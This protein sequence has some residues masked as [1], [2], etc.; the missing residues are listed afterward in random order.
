MTLVVFDMAL[1]IFAVVFACLAVAGRGPAWRRR[2]GLRRSPSRHPQ[3]LVAPPAARPEAVA[4]DIEGEREEMQLAERLVAG[5]LPPAQYQHVM[6]ELAARDA[7]RH[8]VVIP[9]DHR[10]WPVPG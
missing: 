9:P 5:D 8:P 1:T 6:A 2:H 10:G 3:P 4:A 7:R